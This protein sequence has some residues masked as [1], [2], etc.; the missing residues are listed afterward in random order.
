MSSALVIASVTAVLKSLLDN[1]LIQR[2]VAASVGDVSVTALPPDRIATGADERS[3]LNLFLYRVTP[4]TGWR[5]SSLR[6]GDGHNGKNG[7]DGEAKAPAPVGPAP[8]ALDLHYLLTAYGEQDFQAE[9]LL[10]Y[11]MQ[12]LH[13]VATLTPDHI[14]SALAGPNGSGSTLP[15]T[16]AALATST[17]ADAVE[18]VSISS[19]FTSSEEMSRLWSALQARY[20]PSATYK[21]STVLLEGHQESPPNREER[22][23]RHEAPS[24]AARPGARGARK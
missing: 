7:R 2:G 15:P 1:R 11:A 3:Q 6:L 12:L 17:L 8:L 4:N 18:R 24:A 19:E 5:R 9:I 22:P 13:E 20:R 21:V 16:R 14:R 10:G 23:D